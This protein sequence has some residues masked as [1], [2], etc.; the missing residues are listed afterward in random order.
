MLLPTYKN[1]GR[2]NTTNT[3]CGCVYEP[4][5]NWSIQYC[6]RPSEVICERP[7]RVGDSINATPVT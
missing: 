4:D 7:R 2:S 3:C 6:M 5:K 1:L